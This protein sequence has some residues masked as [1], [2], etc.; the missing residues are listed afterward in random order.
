MAK[1][2]RATFGSNLRRLRIAAGFDQAKDLAETVGVTRAAIS[3]WE[4]DRTGLPEVRTLMHLGV[5]LK[6]SVDDLIA[7]LDAAYERAKRVGK[8]RE[9]R[10][11]S[12]RPRAQ[13][14]DGP[15]R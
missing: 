8:R 9:L 13:A 7:D 4:N 12:G 1:S 15:A 14:A 2:K 11:A 5:A 3:R 6:C 10:T